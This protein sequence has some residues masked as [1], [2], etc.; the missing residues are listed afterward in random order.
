MV[1]VNWFFEE[2]ERFFWKKSSIAYKSG[3]SAGFLPKLAILNET[4]IIQ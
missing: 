4:K 2:I 3:D 1:F